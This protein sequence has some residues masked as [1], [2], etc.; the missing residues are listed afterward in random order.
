MIGGCANLEAG[1]LNNEGGKRHVLDLLGELRIDEGGL[2]PPAGT[3]GRARLSR[4][5]LV[6]HTLASVHRRSQMSSSGL[7]SPQVVSQE[8][9]ELPPQPRAFGHQSPARGGCTCRASPMRSRARAGGRRR[10]VREF[11]YRDYL[12]LHGLSLQLTEALAEYW[13]A[14]FATSSASAGED[15]ADMGEGGVRTELPGQGLALLPSATRLV[16]HHPAAKYFNALS[17]GGHRQALRSR[18]RGPSDVSRRLS[19][20]NGNRPVTS[21]C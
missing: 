16:V 7:A 9:R 20:K 5:V 13:H 10:A 17:R 2:C 19:S 6:A 3:G 18:P 4:A 21:R 11:A 12:E 1:A 14:R 8:D 15:S